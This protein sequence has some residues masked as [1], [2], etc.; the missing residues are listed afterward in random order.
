LSLISAS[1]AQDVSTRLKGLHSVLSYKR[2]S[3]GRF[4]LP[5]VTAGADRV[6]LDGTQLAMLLGGF[7]PVRTRRTEAWNPPERRGV[8]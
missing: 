4:Q 3:K 1:R 6:V 8:A 7:D 2:L 5:R